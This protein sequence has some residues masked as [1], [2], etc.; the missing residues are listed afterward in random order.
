M[1]FRIL[2]LAIIFIC[3]CS[4]LPEIQPVGKPS[5]K[6]DQKICSTPFLKGKWQ[7]IHSIQAT[8][9][10]RKNAFIMGVTNISE[11]TRTINV[12]MMTVEGL[13]LFDAQYNGKITINKSIPPFNS[14]KFANGLME[15]IRLIFFKPDGVLQHNGCF[16]DGYRVCRYQN[17]AGDN[18]DIIVKKDNT[19]TIKKYNKYNRLKRF[20]KVDSIYKKTRIPQKIE[21]T[22]YGSRPYSLT[23]DLIEAKQLAR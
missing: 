12:V 2:F 1:R 16:N 6:F 8:L 20:V 5:C 23:L 7:F 15:D 11:R 17:K 3:S 14:T 18:T 4:H 22:G 10:N 13:V 19:W 21:F 9:P